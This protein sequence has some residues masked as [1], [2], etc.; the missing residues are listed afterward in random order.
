VIKPVEPFSSIV[1]VW[2]GDPAVD[3]LK[4]KLDENY[5]VDS[6]KNPAA[7]RDRL[8]FRDGAAPTEWVM[9]VLS[10]SDANTAQDTRGYAAAHW[11]AFLHSVRDIRNH[12]WTP[13]ALP[14]KKL[15][16]VTRDGVEYVD[17]QWLASVM[18][19][20]LRRCAIELGLIAY[21]WNQLSED[22]AK[23]SPGPSRP[24]TDSAGP[25]PSAPST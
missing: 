1:L 11:Y 24:N 12:G 22:D 9:G 7:W 5:L 21:H 8:A 14:G 10:S 15:P 19:G 13:A 23:N 2:Q 20:P 6:M 17:P 3:P 25:A 16:K 18:V 4:S